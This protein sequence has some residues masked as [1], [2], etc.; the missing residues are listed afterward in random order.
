[1]E[2]DFK[3]TGKADEDQTPL[4]KVKGDETEQK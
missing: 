2:L 3:V 1:V 4:L